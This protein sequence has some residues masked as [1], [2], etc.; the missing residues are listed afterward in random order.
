[1]TLPPL[2]RSPSTPVEATLPPLPRAFTR[3]VGML[4]QSAGMLMFL[5]CC[6]LC[7]LSSQWG[8]DEVL[9]RGQVDQ[10]IAQQQQ[11]S[12][13]AEPYFQ[14]MLRNPA[15]T[16]SMLLMMF[17][18]VGGLAL[19]V[20]G[21]GMHSDKRGATA[22]A[23]STACVLL[24]ILV[25]AGVGLWTGQAPWLLRLWHAALTL[26]VLLACVL[27]YASLQEVRRDPPPAGMET[28]PADFDEREWK[29]AWREEQR[30]ER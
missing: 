2:D 6:L 3:G 15:K 18:T 16:G 27:C 20:F 13:P 25:L 8:F 23:L 12:Q 10:W 28:L 17:S 19:A 5:S 21:M 26:V 22:G 11:S 30:S 24:V 4:L 29:K 14:H 7:T 1:M 9:T